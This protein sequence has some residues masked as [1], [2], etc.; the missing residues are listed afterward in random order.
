MLTHR[1]GKQLQYRRGLRTLCG[2]DKSSSSDSVVTKAD[3]YINI[4]QINKAPVLDSPGYSGNTIASFL[5][6]CKDVQGSVSVKHDVEICL[7]IVRCCNRMS[8]S[9]YSQRSFPLRCS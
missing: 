6:L 3:Y 8:P 5:C 4:T 1:D 2:S 7:S 9:R